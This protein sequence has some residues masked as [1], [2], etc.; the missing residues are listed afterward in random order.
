MQ[1]NVETE[2]VMECRRYWRNGRVSDYEWWQAGRLLLERPAGEAAV[3]SDYCEA[4]RTR[5]YPDL[6]CSYCRE[7]P[8]TQAARSLARVRGA[9]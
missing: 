5:I 6:G 4:H 7:R 8:R 9:H 1:R 2:P 3:T